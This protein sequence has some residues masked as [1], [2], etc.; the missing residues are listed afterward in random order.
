MKS[1]NRI[2][3]RERVIIETRYCV[4]KKSMRSIALELNKSPSAISREIAGKPRKGMSR[5]R[6]N[7]AEKKSETKRHQQGRNSKCL[8]EPLRK[9]V[10]KKLKL[11]WS[12]EQISLRLPIEYPQDIA[13]RISY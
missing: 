12:P 3:Y 13:M 5:Y 4:D 8:H 2:T 10:I 7:V 1:F 11:G 9:Y 6:A